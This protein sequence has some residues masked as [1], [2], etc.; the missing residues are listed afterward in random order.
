MLEARLATLPEQSAVYYL[1]V[2]QDGAGEIFGPLD[3]L[4]RVT[5]RGR[6]CADVLLVE[7]TMGHGIVGGSLDQGADGSRRPTGPAG[8]SRRIGRQH[9]DVVT[10]ECRGKSTGGSFGGGASAKRESPLARSSGFKEFSVWDR[11]RGYIVGAA[12]SCLRRRRLIVGLLV[13]RQTTAR[14]RRDLRAQRRLCGQLRANPRSRRA[15]A[16][17]RRTPSARG[18]R[19]SCTTTS[20]S[21]WRCWRSISNC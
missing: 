7:S 6:Q 5:G 3:Y 8:A 16:A 19:A 1:I 20:A 10:P 12:G 21:S 17:G 15:A 2:Y 9:P 4:D 14:P 11:Y 18:S 13:Q